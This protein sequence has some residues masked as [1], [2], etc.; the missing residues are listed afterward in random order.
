[1]NCFDCSTL[2]RSTI[3][4]GSCTTCGAGACADHVELDAHEVAHT[5]GPGNYTP[6]VT[7][8]FTCSSCASAL[9][10]PL[11]PMAGQPAHR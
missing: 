6:K 8:A 5:S 9:A 11:Q 3:A 1:M 7:R 2:G 4:L 10:G